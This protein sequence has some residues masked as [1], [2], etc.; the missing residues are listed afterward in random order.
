MLPF[1]VISST[2]FIKLIAGAFPNISSR[3][4]KTQ[5]NNPLY[6]SGC[7]KLLGK[8]S[9]LYLKSKKGTRGSRGNLE[10]NIISLIS[11]QVT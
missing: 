8:N 9:A 6:L 3:E 10:V 1:A 11:P 5:P 7:M 2:S 4:K